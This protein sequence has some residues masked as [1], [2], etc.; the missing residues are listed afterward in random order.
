MQGDSL[1][2]TLLGTHTAAGAGFVHFVCL[3]QHTGDSVKLAV[4]LTN[5]AANTKITVDLSDQTV[6]KVAPHGTVR[7][8][9]SAHHAANALF[10]VDDRQ[11]VDHGDGVKLA[12]I[13][14]NAAANAADLAVIA[15]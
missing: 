2:G 12:S 6:L 10:T 13:L 1:L 5:R 4:A 7:A 3:L 15:D 9:L 11:I 14:T 8:G